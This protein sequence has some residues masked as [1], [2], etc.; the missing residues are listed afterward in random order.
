MSET[1]IYLDNNATTRPAPEC[2]AAMMACLQMHYGNPSSKHRLGEA[3]KMEVIAARARLAALLGASPAEI[4]F[5]SGGTESIQQAIRGALALAADKRRVVTSAVEH[6]ATLLLLEHLEAQGLEVIRLPVDRQGRLDLA[7]LDA[8]LTPDTGLL[9]LMW[10]NNETGVLFPI[11]EAAALA[12]SR[13]VLFHCDA[14]QAVGKLPIDLRLVPL[15][16]LSLSGHKLH[17]PKG[18]GALFVRKGRKL[19]PLL[20]G[21][22][23]RGRRGSTEN[24]V[25]IVGLGV[26][27]ELA[28]EHLASGMDAVA[29]LRDRLESRLLAAL[30]GASV[31]GAGAPRVAGTSSFNL[32]NV[33]AEL[34]LDKLDR[35]G[36]C[37]SAG[38][39]CS[40]GGTE[41]SHVL[42]AMGLGKEGALAT[43][44]FSLS[45]YTTVAEVDAVCG[46]LPGIVRSL[47]AEAA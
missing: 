44:R 34:V 40:A 46:L 19:P 14:V 9:S 32:G 24:V 21:H 12:A 43:L 10:A 11:A 23:E 45:R 27:A 7:M 26:A 17:G 33:E 4:V 30:P 1:S 6:P 16:F 47:L 28:A 42:T 31:N 15:D 2:V 8:A 37:A 25:G 35:A 22:Q 39:A 36:V 20:L 5:T 41:P 18:I 38:A 13:G 3:A 29:R